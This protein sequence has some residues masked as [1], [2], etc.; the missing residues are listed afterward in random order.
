MQPGEEDAAMKKMPMKKM[1][2][3]MIKLK[4]K[5]KEYEECET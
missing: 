5:T 1:P 3:K 2:T 4:S